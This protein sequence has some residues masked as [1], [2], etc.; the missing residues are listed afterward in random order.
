MSNT[1]IALLRCNTGRL[2]ALA[3]LVGPAEG[4]AQEASLH[5]YSAAPLQAGALLSLW[6]GEAFEPGEHALQ[7][8]VHTR[9][10]GMQLDAAR[11][12][13]VVSSFELLATLGVFKHFDASAGVVAHYAEWSDASRAAADRRVLVGELRVVPRVGLWSNGA[14]SGLAAL[15]S[16]SLSPSDDR[17]LGGERWRFEPRFLASG[18]AGPITVA[19]NLGYSLHAA[20]ERFG[21]AH[22][23][24]LLC[25]AGIS[26]GLSD[27]WSTLA[28]VTSRWHPNGDNARVPSE[29]RVAMR[30]WSGNWGAQLGGGLGL[31]SG[32]SQ[33]D[34]RMMAALSASL[35]AAAPVSA[36]RAPSDRDRDGVPDVSDPCP[37]EP[38]APIGTTELDGCPE[39][40]LQATPAPES[41]EPAEPLVETQQ[42][43]PVRPFPVLVFQRNRAQLDAQHLA[44]LEAVAVQMKEAPPDARFIVEGHSDAGGPPAFN[45]SLSRSR[46]LSVRLQLMQRG[47]SWRRLSIAA[48][49]ASRPIDANGNSTS[50]R[51]T[52][53]IAPSQ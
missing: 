14:G 53:R 9:R 4:R 43:R 28:E 48:Y 6:A 44:T 12:A 26:V 30:F 16:T 45:L 49:G 5:E 27:A 31:S 50:R 38:G 7:L 13:R 8:G 17:A 41:E 51:V 20:G 10:H 42:E 22:K 40:Y 2:L 36:P 24:A 47:V 1:R 39:Q 32:P 34:W 25:G 33:P 35:P 11:E 19:G 52:F 18:V 15:V 37:D 21:Q 46:A 23:D 3:L 29:A